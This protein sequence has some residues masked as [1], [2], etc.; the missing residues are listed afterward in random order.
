MGR[1][2][3]SFS[4]PVVKIPFLGTRGEEQFC[5]LYCKKAVRTIYKKQWK[6][7]VWKFH[8]TIKF[9]MVLS[10]QV[11]RLSVEEQSLV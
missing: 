2:A 11:A 9:K 6:S 10:D 8:V 3:A 5:V 4:D 1:S 7:R